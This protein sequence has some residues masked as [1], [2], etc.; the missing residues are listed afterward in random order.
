MKTAEEYL[1]N[2]TASTTREELYDIGKQIQID[3]IDATV[4]MC[5]EKA[6]A[7]EGW[8]TGYSGS[9]ASVDKDSILNCA[10]ILKKEIK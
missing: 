6:E 4:K 10:E 2:V 5:A 3:A 9:A 7:I 8:N 1:K